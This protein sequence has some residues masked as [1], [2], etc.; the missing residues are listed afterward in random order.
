MG[1]KW[2]SPTRI[3]KSEERLE[4]KVIIQKIGRPKKGNSEVPGSGIGKK[5]TVSTIRVRRQCS[6][7]GKLAEYEYQGVSK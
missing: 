6:N 7:T 3:T 5:N 1:S 2:V 4:I